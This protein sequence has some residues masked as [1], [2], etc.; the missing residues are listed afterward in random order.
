MIDIGKLVDKVFD[1]FFLMLGVNLCFG[2][3][4]GSCFLVV[5]FIEFILSL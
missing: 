2:I 4:L 1:L 3:M 5:V